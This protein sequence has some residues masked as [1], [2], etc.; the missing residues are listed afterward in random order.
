M[1]ARRHSGADLC[2][3]ASST[4][5][6][7]WKASSGSWS[8]LYQASSA[9][10][11]AGC[12]FVPL[13]RASRCE[14]EGGHCSLVGA[15]VVDPGA[16]E[17]DCFDLE[18]RLF[19]QFAAETVDRVFAFVEEAA[20]EIPFALLGLDRATR[21]QNPAL[22]VGDHGRRDRGRGRVADKPA[23]RADGPTW[24]TPDRC[25]TARAVLPAIEHTHRFTIPTGHTPTDSKREP[26]EGID[27]IS[28]ALTAGAV[29]MRSAA[30]AFAFRA[31]AF[32]CPVVSP[33][34]F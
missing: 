16:E 2:R 26:K 25:R 5:A 31:R 8:G 21:E 20:G 3:Q 29:A 6:L 34:P 19:A 12:G 32:S 24:L 18:T 27:A 15:V 7:T 10:S 33:A 14:V 9:T 11:S 30:H 17:L 22:L 13:A 4:S 23:R 1:G 28:D